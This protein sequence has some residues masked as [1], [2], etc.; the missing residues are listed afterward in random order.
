[1]NGDGEVQMTSSGLVEMNKT[2][3]SREQELND[4]IERVRQ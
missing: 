2:S 4:E 1:M 3:K